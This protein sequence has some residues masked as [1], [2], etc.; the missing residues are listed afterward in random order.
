MHQI[1]NQIQ[2]GIRKAVHGDFL[3]CHVTA[4]LSGTGT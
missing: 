3:S 4:S 2:R 1:D